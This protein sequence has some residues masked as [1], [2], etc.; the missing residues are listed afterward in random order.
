MSYY[1]AVV[2]IKYHDT[3]SANGARRLKA[4]YRLRA[5]QK[6]ILS[7]EMNRQ[8]PKTSILDA[9]LMLESACDQ[10]SE[11]TIKKPLQKSGNL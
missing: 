1:Y 8:L 4:H 7:V 3:K 9:M 2:S 11:S 6:M 5:V 10:V